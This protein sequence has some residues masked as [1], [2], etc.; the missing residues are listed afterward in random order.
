MKCG[1]SIFAGMW[2][3]VAMAAS[4]SLSAQNVTTLRPPQATNFSGDLAVDA[5]GDIYAADFGVL[6]NNANGTTVYRVTPDGQFS[7]FATGFSGASGNTF[8][9][10]G[11]LFQSNIAASRVDRV[12]PAGVRSTFATSA[13]GISNPVGL[14]HDSSG[15]LYV[16]NCGNSTIQRVTPQGQGSLFSSFGLLSCPN[17]LTIDND[18][19]L[20]AANFNNGIIVRIAPDGSAAFFARTPG[21][22]TKSQG[23]NGHI[24]F[25]NGRLYVVSNASH[26]VFELLLDGT[27][28]LIAGSGV[29]GR[30]DGPLLQAQFSLPNGIALSP[31]G[32]TLH[33]NDSEGLLNNN[34][35]APNVI[36]VIPLPNIEPVFAINPG[37]NDAWFN[38]ATA[39][40]GFF[41]TV[42]AD[43]G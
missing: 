22:P 38:A 13:A 41:I 35:I 11:N 18:G 9:A 28:N 40:Q 37:L 1:T 24:T 7:V 36:R 16:S 26:Q 14:A 20:Y 32:S 10:Q 2:L 25:G 23:S 21:G 34:D 6:L 30:Q 39:G 4:T 19:N 42:F 17:G 29:R 5:D 15:N 8:D 43:I 3:G 33:V 31:D 12:T 27:L